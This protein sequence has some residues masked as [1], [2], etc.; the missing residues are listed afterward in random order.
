MKIPRC[1]AIG[2]LGNLQNNT[3]K[4]MYGV[5]EKKMEEEVPMNKPIPRPMSNKYKENILGIV[6]INVPS[7]E[8]G[9]YK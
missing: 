9:T 7:E 5:D 1:T 6:K 3:F 2:F 4:E 8:R